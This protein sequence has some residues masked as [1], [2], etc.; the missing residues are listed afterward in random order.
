MVHLNFSMLSPERHLEVRPDYAVI[1]K[2]RS[3][4]ECGQTIPA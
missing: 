3:Q 4:N 1:L 2:G